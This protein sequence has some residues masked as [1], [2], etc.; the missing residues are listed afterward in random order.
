MLATNNGVYDFNNRSLRGSKRS[1]MNSTGSAGNLVNGGVASVAMAND[2]FNNKYRTM[3][4]IHR[5]PDWAK[6]KNQRVKG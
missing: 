6:Q 2:N 5:Q 4:E 3:H 1:G